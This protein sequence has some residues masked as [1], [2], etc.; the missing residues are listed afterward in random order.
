[1]HTVLF[2]AVFVFLVRGGAA[3]ASPKNAMRHLGPQIHQATR[4]ASVVVANPK[5]NNDAS[6]VVAIPEKRQTSI[7]PLET[8]KRRLNTRQDPFSIHKF[9]GFGW[10]V[11]ATV[12]F[13]AGAMTGFTVLPEVLE[14]FTYLF[15]ASTLIQS[16][17]SIPMALQYRSKEPVAK[18]GFISSAV[19]T[20]SLAFTG[21]WLSPF[22]KDNAHPPTAAALI[23]I[24]VSADMIYSM[25]SI[26]DM[27][28]VAAK[29][30]ENGDPASV[31]KYSTLIS[32]APVGLPMNA[33]LL[34][35]LIGHFDN[36]RDYF[37]SVIASNGST[38]ELVYYASM[39]TSI[40]VCV[41]NLAATLHHRKLISKDIENLATIGAIVVT[42][43]FNIRAAGSF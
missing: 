15:L 36:V 37:L 26:Q 1:M 25:T 16:M 20:T 2:L 32:M 40:S 34:Y 24:L 18:R 27:V 23:A 10:W 5:A 14:P 8:W 11:S 22:A 42:L 31:K 6:V 30:R 35:H 28:Q 13:G 39:V 9:A 29:I 4:D 17:S 21:Y 41:G 43:V 38:P 12:I 33:F 3:I 19:T 7:P